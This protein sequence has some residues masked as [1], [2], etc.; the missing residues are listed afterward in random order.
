LKNPWIAPRRTFRVRGLLPRWVSEVLE[1]CADH[2]RVQLRELQPGGR[3]AGLLLH[4]GEKQ[5]E[6]VSV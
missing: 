5:P 4:E 6:G 3:C 1:E 2:G